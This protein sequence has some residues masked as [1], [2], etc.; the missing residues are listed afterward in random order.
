MLIIAFGMIM[1][2]CI[3]ASSV[4]RSSSIKATWDVWQDITI[5]RFIQF[6]PGDF[7]RMTGQKMNFIQRVSFGLIK[8]RMRNSLK[9]KGDMTVNKFMTYPFKPTKWWHFVLLGILA[10]LMIIVFITVAKLGA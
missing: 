9:K 7:H 8:H 4:H 1:H 3:A 6:S 2:N 10:I 5:R